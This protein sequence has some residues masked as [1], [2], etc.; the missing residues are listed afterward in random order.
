MATNEHAEVNRRIQDF[1][2]RLAGN[3]DATVCPQHG[4][5]LAALTQ[6]LPIPAQARILDVGSGT[7]VMLPLLAPVN[8]SGRMVVAIDLA[9]EMMR[10]AALRNDCASKAVACAQADAMQLPFAT[11]AFDWIVCNSVFPH[12]LDQQACVNELARTLKQGGGFVVCHSQSREAINAFHHAR[13]GL[14]GGHQLPDDDAMAAIMSNAGLA[15]TRRENAEEHYL[16]LAVKENGQSTRE[17]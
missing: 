2:D 3:W 6:T 5:R 8:G 9:W 1:F 13:G 4:P 15:V 7:G 10:M 12:F 14:I 16:L 17:R 11:G